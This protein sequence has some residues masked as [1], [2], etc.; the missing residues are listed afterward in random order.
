MFIK[1]LYNIKDF[2]EKIIVFDFLLIRIVVYY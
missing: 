2:I 1:R